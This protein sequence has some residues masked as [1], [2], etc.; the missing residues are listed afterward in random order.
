MSVR[1]EGRYPVAT[2]ERIR[3]AGLACMIGGGLEVVFGLV[4]FFEGFTLFPVTEVVWSFALLGLMGGLLGMLW[5]RATGSG[6]GGRLILVVPLVGMLF[7]LAAMVYFIALGTRVDELLTPIGAQ[8]M[9]FGMI[10]V[11]VAA[12][13]AKVWRGWRVLVP[14][15][16]GLYFYLVPF[17]GLILMGTGKPPYTF[18][19]LWGMTWMLLGYAIS[20]S[21]SEQ[22]SNHAL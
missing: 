10:L 15:V 8:L 14:F 19:G 16:V 20:S 5:L 12:L 17:V 3:Y 6:R 2:A 21:A 18:V 4:Y 1:I 11:G 13:R 22:R 9:A 7:H